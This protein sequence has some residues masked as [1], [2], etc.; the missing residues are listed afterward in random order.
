VAS[1]LMR[2]SM[3]G[4]DVRASVAYATET[5]PITRIAGCAGNRTAAQLLAMPR[6]LVLLRA[7]AIGETDLICRDG[8]WFL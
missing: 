2:T 1:T 6:D 4:R 7:R 8:K 5:L 3:A